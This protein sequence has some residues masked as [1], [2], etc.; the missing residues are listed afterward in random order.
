M[1]AY[2]LESSI[3]DIFVPIL[4]LFILSLSSKRKLMISSKRKLMKRS[5]ATS[6]CFSVVAHSRLQFQL[7][8]LSPQ[9]S[10]QVFEFGSHGHERRHCQCLKTQSGLQSHRPQPAKPEII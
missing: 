5:P 1:Q 8:A 7:R 2:I 9:P 10:R 3:V 4:Y 6:S